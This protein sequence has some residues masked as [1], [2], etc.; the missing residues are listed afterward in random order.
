VS[1][2][3]CAQSYLFVRVRLGGESGLVHEGEEGIDGSFE[4]TG[5]PEYVGE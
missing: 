3:L 1:V 5:T 4:R 2:G